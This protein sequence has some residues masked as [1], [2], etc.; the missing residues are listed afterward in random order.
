MR[1]QKQRILWY[2]ADG[3]WHSALKLVEEFGWSWNQRK[4]EMARLR[5]LRFEGRTVA[6]NSS[7]W[8]YRLLTPHAEIDFEKCCR[9][10]QA[11]LGKHNQILLAI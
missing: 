7:H 9:K 10:P 8:E 3:K 5:G 11:S 4:N 2:M 6:G 1:T